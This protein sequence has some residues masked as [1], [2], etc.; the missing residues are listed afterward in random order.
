MEQVQVET[1]V[2]KDKAFLAKL[3]APLIS[4]W[5]AWLNKHANLG[6]SDTAVTWLIAGIMVNAAAFITAHKWKTTS[7]AKALISADAGTP[8]AQAPAGKVAGFARLSVLFV[9]VLTLSAC[10]T[11]KAWW[12]ATVDCTG[13]DSAEILAQV[14]DIIAKLADQDWVAAALDGGHIVG[15]VQACALETVRQAGLKNHPAVTP[16]VAGNAQALKD[17]LKKAILN[18]PPLP[19]PGN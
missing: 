6:L 5:V 8:P 10:A 4:I 18:A 2:W 1:P 17:N 11:F 16:L 9:M 19:F 7:L 13:Q 15:E 3:I 14:P 12:S